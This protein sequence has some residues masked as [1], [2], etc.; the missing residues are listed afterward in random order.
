M[1]AVL[2]IFSVGFIVGAMVVGFYQSEK[3]RKYKHSVEMERA[4]S[5][6]NEH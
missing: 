4:R 1:M 2:F 5:D 6:R 3:F